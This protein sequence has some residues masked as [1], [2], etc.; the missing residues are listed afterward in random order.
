[1]EITGIVKI[2]MPSRSGSTNN[3][4][5][6]A[7]QSFL[8]EY[9]R[10]NYASNVLLEVFGADKIEMFKLQVGDRIT[11]HFDISAHEYNGRWYND[12]RV[13]KVVRMVDTAPQPAQPVANAYGANHGAANAVPSWAN[14]SAVQQPQ[15]V[16]SQPVASQ[17]Q[18][19][20]Y[21]QSDL[22]F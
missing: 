6:W 5:T 20:N 1:M 18:Q 7:A 14:A 12:L 3:G 11:A 8:M 13:W 17:P 15:P 22:P 4:S 2:M 16:A 9:M 19:P 21:T 10:G